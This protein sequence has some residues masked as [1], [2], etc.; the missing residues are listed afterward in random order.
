MTPITSKQWK[1]QCRQLDAK[2]AK[3][4][5]LEADR[6]MPKAGWIRTIRQAL[7]MTISHLAKKL[8]TSQPNMTNLEKGEMK[9][10]V[11]LNTLSKTANALGC[12]L[13]YFFVPRQPIEKTLREQ[14]LKVAQ[15]TFAEVS[16]TMSLEAQGLSKQEIEAQI[17]DLA[18]E[19]LQKPSRKLWSDEK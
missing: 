17:K 7:G 1:L 18:D 4:R 16:H 9:G 13:V 5:Q 8:G 2:F 12:D 15:K 6:G 11:S 14:A 10:S 19:I 3:L